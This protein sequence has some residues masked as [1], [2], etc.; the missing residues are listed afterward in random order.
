MFETLGIAGLQITESAKDS[1]YR[2]G[3][4]PLSGD[5]AYML[6]TSSDRFPLER[7]LDAWKAGKF[8]AHAGYIVSVCNT[9]KDMVIQHGERDGTYKPKRLGRVFHDGTFAYVPLDKLSKFL[10]WK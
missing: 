4:L 9:Y 5:M 1:L 8:E 3:R 7:F 10:T 6:F 2:L